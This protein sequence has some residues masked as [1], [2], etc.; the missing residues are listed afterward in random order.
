MEVKSCHKKH[1]SV[2]AAP[3]TFPVISPLISLFIT[4]DFQVESQENK[5]FFLKLQ[6][7]DYHTVWD[8]IYNVE[9]I[10][11]CICEQ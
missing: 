7:I 4:P 8:K 11:M 6:K 10:N 2:K 3:N 1:L 5:M 9:C